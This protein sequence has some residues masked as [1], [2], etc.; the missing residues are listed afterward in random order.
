MKKSRECGSSGNKA[1]ESG[2]IGVRGI[3]SKK[4]TQLELF[5]SH[6]VCV[7]RCCSVPNN[8]PTEGD[9]FCWPNVYLALAFLQT[10]D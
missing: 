9:N 5:A 8:R 7:H 10:N 2:A 1:R 6:A 3:L 4:K